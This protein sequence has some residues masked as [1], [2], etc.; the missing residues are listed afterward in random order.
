MPKY[1]KVAQSNI[2]ITVEDEPF[3]GGGEGNLH[4]I[5][6]PAEWKMFVAKFYH[7]HKLSPQREEKIRYLIDNPPHESVQ[8][9]SEF[10]PVVWLVDAIYTEKGNEF[11]GFVMPFITGDKLEIL[12]M[13]KISPKEAK[14]WGRFDFKNPQAFNLRLRLC[15]NL[16]AAIYQVH[17]SDRYV[18][19]DLKPENVIVKP[20]GLLSLVDTDSV[21]VLDGA[22]NVVYPA[23]VATPEFTPPEYYTY[24]RHESETVGEEW[25]RFSLAVIL[26]KLLFGIHPYTAS[27]NA[28]Y[29]GLVSLHEKIEHGLFVHAPSKKQYM[30]VVPPPHKAWEKLAEPLRALFVQCFEQGHDAPTLR[31]TAE[32]WCVALLDTFG[33]EQLKQQFGQLLFRHRR[34]AGTFLASPSSKVELPK[35]KV[36]ADQWMPPDLLQ[37]SQSNVPTLNTQLGGNMSNISDA[38]KNSLVYGASWGLFVFLLVV[39]VSVEADL[40]NW[41]FGHLLHDNA[42]VS[43]LATLILV[44]IPQLILPFVLVKTG[45]LK[46]SAVAK[47]KAKVKEQLRGYEDA[48]KELMGLQKQLVQFATQ[49]ITTFDDFTKEVEKR[50]TQFKKVLKTK[51]ESVKTLQQEQ[52]DKIQNLQTTFLERAKVNPKVQQIQGKTLEELREKLELEEQLQLSKHKQKMQQLQ[53]D[54]QLLTK[55]KA[56]KDRLE[57]KNKS[58]IKKI[59]D[60]CEVKKIEAKME[61]DRKIKETRLALER[62]ASIAD[63]LAKHVPISTDEQQ[64]LI[65]FL[66]LNALQFIDQANSVDIVNSTITLKDGKQIKLTEAGISSPMTAAT[67]LHAWWNSLQGAIQLLNIQIKALENTLEATY[68]R[69]DEEK[70]TKTK[71][72][73]DRLQDEIQSAGLTVIDG[74]YKSNIKDQMQV[75]IDAKAFLDE[76][77]DE[78]N[79]QFEPINQSMTEQ[80]ERILS[81]CNEENEKLK[82]YIEENEKAHQD[83]LKALVNDKAFVNINQQIQ[84]K[85]K[86]VDVTIQEYSTAEA[87]LL[88]KS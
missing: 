37:A 39:M 36:T 1:Y 42:L 46:D 34:M 16:S 12:C 82:N 86:R 56:E 38:P 55:L 35:I 25:D 2:R 41:L 13:G 64:K 74:Q 3:A 83:K 53:Q 68:K 72:A 57:R 19:V 60:D 33:D 87:E 5:I 71:R 49:R 18:L 81:E 21:E 9:R 4:K 77:I 10:S 79:A 6:A 52:N 11:A 70:A 15:F 51:D 85:S 31:P 26:Y 75:Y 17:S 28:P 67:L 29:E 7:K 62:E 48:V 61:H 76:L 50:I 24:K 40:R 80:Y 32:E 59:E 14:D 43:V 44:A 78:Y 27:N 30:K 45:L 8:A 54:P 84:E 73:E 63:R 22:G 58:A 69:I 88:K 23:P 65:E 47:L 66:Q 20:N